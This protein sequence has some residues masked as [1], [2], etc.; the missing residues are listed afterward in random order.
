M[1]PRI[2]LMLVAVVA[3]QAAPPSPS[4]QTRPTARPTGPG[5][6]DPTRLPSRPAAPAGP[7]ATRPFFGPSEMPTGTASI[8]GR[9]ISSESGRP[10][11]RARVSLRGRAGDSRG[12]ATVTDEE[13]RFTFSSLAAGR[14]DL[15]AGKARY[16][17]MAYGARR[18]G[19]SGRAVELAEGQQLDDVSLSLA[20]AGV[21]TGRVVD[22]A[23]EPVVGATVMALRRRP[24]A[25]GPNL[26]PVNQPRT[27]DDTGTFRLFGLPPGRYY[28]SARAD[29]H[30]FSGDVMDTAVTGL[31][32]TFHPSTPAISEAQPVEVAAGA[33]MLA[34]ITLVATPM[35]RV[36]GSVVDAAGR[37]ALTGMVMAETDDATPFSNSRS[38]SP[39]GSSGTFTLSGLPPGDYI[40]NVR[41]IFDQADVLDMARTGRAT[42]DA[43][44]MPISVGVAGIE[45][46]RLVVPAPVD[47]P[48]RVIFEGGRPDGARSLSIN[49]QMNN[50]RMGQHR[51]EVGADGRFT[52]R[53]RPGTWQ[54]A[55]WPGPG[56]MV[57]HVTFRG[58]ETHLGEPVEITSEPDG[59]LEITVTNQLTRIEGTVVDGSRQP[60]SD[61]HVLVVPQD[62]PSLEQASPLRM[63][64]QPAG[65]DGRFEV[66][67]LPPGGYLVMA[68]PEVEALGGFD[69]SL[70]ET[71]RDAAARVQVAFGQPQALTLR[72]AALP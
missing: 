24:R 5:G 70:F 35:V 38:M 3:A 2:L 8:S 65:R 40:L 43:Y 62:D 50:G 22:D 31:A 18:P 13:G 14:Y 27:T 69:E 53:V 10:I 41:G 20:T 29:E 55:A 44:A 9:V 16:V 21:I 17:D 39:I 42:E 64:L 72:L 71:H 52:L 4:A 26:F 48:G 36:S 51:A 23:G 47:V 56:W 49:A 54:I 46:L 61:Y 1:S 32:P 59:R 11:R 63:R 37:P 67:G 66:T 68:I 30:G 6:V 19:G 33:E 58:Q 57:K 60:V 28:V 7:G 12:L 45:D 25:G 15:R 34:D